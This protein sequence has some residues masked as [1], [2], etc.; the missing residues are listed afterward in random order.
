[1]TILLVVNKI[2]LWCMLI[3]QDVLVMDRTLDVSKCLQNIA[4]FFVILKYKQA[5]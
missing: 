3:E 5:I 1:M 2:S 4:I